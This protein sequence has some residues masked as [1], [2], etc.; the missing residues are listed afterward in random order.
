MKPEEH[1]EDFPL[2]CKLIWALVVLSALVA[3]FMCGV[4]FEQQRELQRL[5][6]KHNQQLEEMTAIVDD[7]SAAA[8]L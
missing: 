5:E 1:P 8:A 2:E 3:A 6:E 7:I 4:N